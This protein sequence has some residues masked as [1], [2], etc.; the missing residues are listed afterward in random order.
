MTILVTGGAGYIGSHT[1]VD[2]LIAGH[3][4]IATDI[5][6]VDN[7]SNSDVSAIEGIKKITGKDFP[8]YQVDLRDFKAVVDIFARHKIDCIIHFAGLKSV[9]DSVAKPTEYYDNNVN[10]TLNLCRAMKI[11]SVDKIIFSSSATVYRADNPMPLAEDAT[12]RATSPYG[13]SKIMCEQ[14]LEDCAAAEGWSAVLLRY[15]NPVGSH[16]SGLIDES[17]RGVPGNLMPFIIQTAKGIRKELLIFGNDY[18]T[19]DGTGV[20]DYLHVEDLARGHSLAI[21]FCNKNKGCHAFNLG[22]GQGVSVLEMVNAF[23]KVNKT[24]IPYKIAPRRPGDNPI[25]LANPK[26]AEEVLG[27]KAIKTLENMVKTPNL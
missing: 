17:P 3:N 16:P 21:D 22:T 9:P 6:V 23:E 2:L 12:L 13:W 19:T 20:R 25:S 26:K 15:F 8:F 24:Q 4:L 10:S 11:H 14:I 18:E 27:F 1:C 7:F 5:V